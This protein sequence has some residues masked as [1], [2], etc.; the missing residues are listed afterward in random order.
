MVKP[1]SKEYF[2]DILNNLK[3]D[4]YYESKYGIRVP[5]Q[6]ATIRTTQINDIKRFIIDNSIIICQ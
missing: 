2:E 1:Y 6:A 3:K 4:Y 5:V